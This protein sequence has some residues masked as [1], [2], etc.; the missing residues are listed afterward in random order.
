MTLIERMAEHVLVADGA[1]G[2]EL[3]RAGLP[4]GTGGEGWNADRPDVVVA[5]HRAY[6]EAG[7]DIVLTN[8]FGATRWVLERQG[9]AGRRDEL[10]RAAVRLARQA[11]G[12]GR[13][14]L[15][16]LGPTGQLI[17]PLGPVTRSELQE[18]V[19]ARCRA[20]LEEGVD[21]MICE[22][23]TAGDEAELAVEAAL[24]A[25]APFVIASFAFDKR[26]NGRVRTMMGLAPAEAA[27][28]ARAAGALIVGANCGTHL[29]ISDFAVLAGELAAASGLR[30]MIQPNAGQPRL[31]GGRAVYDMTGSAFAASMRAVLLEA[32]SIVGGCCGTGP[33]HIRAL[34]ALVDATGPWGQRRT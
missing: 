19:R 1:M 33:D 20:Q 22:T 34:R 15:G 2:T 8:T 11:A 3:Q 12:P 27:E 9:L 5:I 17:E 7:S 21:G 18:D 25:G 4:I 31:E 14:V 16:D 28:R 30:V 10:N 32:P 6:V 26:P 13:F 23:L 24:E 29:E